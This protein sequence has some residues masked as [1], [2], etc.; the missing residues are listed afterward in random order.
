[1]PLQHTYVPDDHRT[2]R[3]FDVPLVLSGHDHHRVDEVVDGTRLLKPGLDA[4]Y[5]TVLTIEWAHA[6]QK[7][8]TIEAEF[9]PLSEWDADATMAAAA[10][11]AYAPAWHQSR[12]PH[13]IDATFVSVSV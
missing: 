1:M 6:Q 5:A 10:T 8:P 3:E 7:E 12:P 4:I 13:A 2:C 9:V 11:E